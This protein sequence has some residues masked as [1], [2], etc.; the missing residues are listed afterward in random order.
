MKNVNA[1]QAEGW[2]KLSAKCHMKVYR[3]RLFKQ[4]HVAIVLWSEERI[5]QGTSWLRT[6]FHFDANLHPVRGNNKKEVE[7]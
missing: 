5:S 1:P 4:H 6:Q 2:A 3:R 7:I